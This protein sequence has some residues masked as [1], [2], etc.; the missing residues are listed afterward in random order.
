MIMTLT[1]SAAPAQGRL[2]LAVKWEARDGEADAVADVLRRMAAAV[3]S[4]PG[5]LLF[6]PHRS[7]SNDREFFLYELF[8]D[9]GAFAAHQETEHFKALVLGEA[10]PK[11]AKRERVPFVPL[12]AP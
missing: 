2:A 1:K 11:L 10:L 5:T 7:P 4:E 9:D 6:W 8:A 12:Q 3:K